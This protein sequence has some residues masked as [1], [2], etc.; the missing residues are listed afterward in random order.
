MER[1]ED[2]NL[3]TIKLY[4]KRML[5]INKS[6]NLTA[7]RDYDKGLVLHV[8]DS[9]EG[10]GLARTLLEGRMADIGSGCGFPGVALAVALQAPC[11]LID[12]STKKMKAVSSLLGDLGLGD[13]IAT[14]P[15]RL[16][17]YA[18]DN[19]SCYNLITARALASIRV[20][21]ELASPLLELGGHLLLYKSSKVEEELAEAEPMADKVGMAFASRKDVELSNGDPRS[22]VVFKKV[23]EPLVDLPRRVGKAQKSPLI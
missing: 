22:L 20:V 7:V 23:H 3:Q 6:I 21:L 13:L 18:L 17:E 12:S 2:A 8:E 4:L 16:E 5:E 1:L 15:A 9:L 11:D 14:H 19:P 10:L